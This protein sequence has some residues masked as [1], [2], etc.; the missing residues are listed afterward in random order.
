MVRVCSVRRGRSAHRPPSRA[1]CGNTSR[2]SARVFVVRPDGLDHEIEFVGA[3]DFPGDAVIL[4]WSYDS[5]FGE[6]IE[7]VDPSRRVIFHEEH[8]TSFAVRP[9]EQ[10]KTIGAEVEHGWEE[11]GVREP[12]LPRPTGSSVVGLAARLPGAGY[13][14]SAELAGS[15][16][17]YSAAGGFGFL[18]PLRRLSPPS[19]K[20]SEFSTRRSA[21]AVAMVVL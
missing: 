21:I 8:N 6:V 10:K 11:A 12:K 3:V 20:I 9:R 13:H 5:G 15:P 14:H 7:P 4:A 19:R 16:A 2:G 1:V 18:F 17:A